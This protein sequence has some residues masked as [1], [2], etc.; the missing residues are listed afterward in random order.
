MNQT[1]Q[2]FTQ[3]QNFFSGLFQVLLIDSK[4]IESAKLNSCFPFRKPRALCKA[5]QYNFG[6]ESIY[7]MIKIQTNT[8]KAAGDYIDLL[9][10]YMA[11]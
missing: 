6:D 9:G 1:T 3:I 8:F 5:D 4:F 10:K 2:L 7:R 11:K